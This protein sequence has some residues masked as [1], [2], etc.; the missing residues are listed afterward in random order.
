M[1]KLVPINREKHGNKFWQRPKT[2]EFVK[3]SALVPLVSKDLSKAV[4]EMPIGFVKR[5]DKFMLT[6]LLGYEPDNNLFVDQDGKW[7]GKYIPSA[8]KW[9]PFQLAQDR[10][11]QLVFCVDE[12]SGLITDDPNDK[13]FLDDMGQ[14][15]EDLHH[16]VSFFKN[17]E[18]S[19]LLT[20]KACAALDKHE[21]FQPWPLKISVQSGLHKIED[22]FRVDEEKFNNLSSEV[23]GELH[24]AGALPVAYCHFLSQQHLPSLCNLDQKQQQKEVDWEFSFDDRLDF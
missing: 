21:L 5:D 9:Y 20:I 13:P 24:R 18:R 16:V 10:S 23:A 12:E 8:F 2:Y 6:A 3:K 22:L 11:N 14:M 1:P 17:V 15:S 19:R 7:L 4:M